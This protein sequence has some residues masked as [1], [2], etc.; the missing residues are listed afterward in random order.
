MYL[1]GVGC[2]VLPISFYPLTKQNHSSPD[3][4]TRYQQVR[5]QHKAPK[6]NRAYWLQWPEYSVTDS[7]QTLLRIAESISN[8]ADPVTKMPVLDCQILLQPLIMP[9]AVRHEL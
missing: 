1:I 4:M 8:S 3:T 2:F 7:T 5:S 6:K 9:T